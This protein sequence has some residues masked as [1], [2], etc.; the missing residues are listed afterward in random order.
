MLIL[1]NVTC[2]YGAAEVV[3][4]L[5]LKVEPNRIVALLGPNGAGKSSTIMT[6][7]GHVELFGGKISFEGKDITPLAPAE[8]TRAGLGLVPEGRRIFSDLS[9]A[10]NLLVGGYILSKED[11][12][13]AEEEVLSVFPRLK[14]RH[15]QQ[16]GTLSGGEQQMLAIGRALMS[17]PKLLMVDELSLGLMPAMVDLCF[18]AISNL[19][20]SGMSCLVVEQNTNMA[21]EHADDIYVLSAGKLIHSGPASEMRG[22]AEFINTLLGLE[23]E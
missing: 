15:L 16:A 1:E 7:A 5:S 18:E 4:D 12:K 20:D 22:N 6:I 13:D 19:R 3:Q 10:E 2:G 8:R 21:L 9:V 14:D 17:R 11:A 23:Q